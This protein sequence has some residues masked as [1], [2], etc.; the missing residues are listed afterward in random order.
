M[1]DGNERTTQRDERI[2]LGARL[3]GG[4]MVRLFVT[5]AHAPRTPSDYFD[6]DESGSSRILA[7]SVVSLNPGSVR[8][9]GLFFRHPA[10][11]VNSIMAIRHQR[12]YFIV[13]WPSRLGAQIANAFCQAA[14]QLPRQV[15]ADIIA[16]C[17]AGGR[18]IVA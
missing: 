3:Q 16:K 18:G 9:S 11:S 6:L 10:V 2:D 12:A 1:C 7:G 5:V 17:P 14:K 15:A 4:V 8:G 13:S